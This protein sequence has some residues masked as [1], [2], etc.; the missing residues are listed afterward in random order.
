MRYKGT[1]LADRECIEAF[2]VIK[3]M[4]L[5]CVYVIGPQ[6]GRPLKIGY[7]IDVV[8]RLSGMQVHN[9]VTLGVHNC[10]WT[11]G[12]PDAKSLE[13]A[14]H[15]R[16]SRLITGEWFD[17]SV[18]EAD[19][20]LADAA[21]TIENKPMMHDE[22]LRHVEP[23]RAFVNYQHLFWPNARRMPDRKYAA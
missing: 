6:H 23:Y 9:W 16:A 15:Q 8:T 4:G 21:K 13:K 14:C 3:A 1:D 7:A 22:M 19:K 10:C 12:L 2:K 20:A 17:I 11:H 5:V 18:N